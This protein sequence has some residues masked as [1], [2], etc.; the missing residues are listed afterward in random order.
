MISLICP[1]LHLSLRWKGKITLITFILPQEHI[2]NATL[3]G[4]VA[5]GAAADLIIQPYGA[6]IIGS[7]AGLVSV[8]GFEYV[9]VSATIDL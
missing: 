1:P 3:A 5:V 9:S 8:F 2:Q 7:I 6:L 4:G